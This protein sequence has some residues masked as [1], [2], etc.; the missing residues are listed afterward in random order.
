MRR[1]KNDKEVGTGGGLELSR[2]P[3]PGEFRVCEPG[4]FYLLEQGSFQNNALGF[5]LLHSAA[6]AHT[7]CGHPF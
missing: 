1:V 5:A 7:E 2:P 4:R 3:T 6:G